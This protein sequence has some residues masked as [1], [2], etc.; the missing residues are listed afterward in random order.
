MF[1]D[2]HDSL[3][4]EPESCALDASGFNVN[5][6]LSLSLELD[7]SITSSTVS[8]EILR[9]PSAQLEFQE[10][11]SNGTL[12]L[13]PDGT[14]QKPASEISGASQIYFS[15]QNES[16][17]ASD[18]LDTSNPL[19]VDNLLNIPHTDGLNLSREDIDRLNDRTVGIN[20]DDH[21]RDISFG[22]KGDPGQCCTRH[23]CTGASYCDASYGDF[24]R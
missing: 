17:Y 23:C 11:S 20:R 6:A 13:F 10:T 19:D 4:V 24:H 7:E 14:N 5:E 8:D 1:E 15:N 22:K 3:N 2:I 12:D 9:M 18:Y 21:R 16:L